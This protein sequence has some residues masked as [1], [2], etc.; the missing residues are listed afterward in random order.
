MN[1][2]VRVPGLPASSLLLAGLLALCGVPGA[3]TIQ[4]DI[5][6]LQYKETSTL[7]NMLSLVEQVSEDVTLDASATFSAERSKDLDRFTD[8]RSGSAS[9][10]YKP[11]DSVELSANLSRLLDMKE[12]YGGLISDQLQNTAT[13][14]V[15]CNPGDWLSMTVGMG[16]HFEEYRTVSGDSL[17][18]GDDRGGVTNISVSANYGLAE[19]LSASLTF[20]EDRTLGRQTDR[21]QDD[22]SGRVSYE[23]PGMFDGGSL[24]AQIGASRQQVVYHD[25]SYSNNLHSYCSSFTVTCPTMLQSLSLELTANWSWEDK[26]WESDEDSTWS[27]ED[28]RD[29]L[30]QQ[31]GLTGRV[32]WNLMDDLSLEF[33][34]GRAFTREDRKQIA[35][36]VSDLFDVWEEGDDRSLVAK[37]TYDIGEARITFDR[38]I[39]LY[40]FDTYGVWEDVFGNPQEDNYDRDELR[41]SMTLAADIPVDGR[42]TLGALLQAQRQET[43]YIFAEQSGNNKVSSTYSFSP[44]ATYQ[45]GGGWKLDETLDFS[46][47]YT[48]FTYPEYSSTGNNLL[49]RRVESVLSFRRI[50]SDSTQLGFTNRFRFQDNGAYESSVYSRSEERISNKVTLYGGFHI[51]SGLGVTPTYSY[52]YSRRVLLGSSVPPSV[53]NLHHVGIDCRMDLG[54]GRLTLNATR[55]FYSDDRPSYWT[56][57]AGFGY[58]F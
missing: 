25:S 3:Y 26:Y 50:S 43:I 7:T 18:S 49:F 10:T 28:S 38:V 8:T 46:A 4:Y 20:G 23:F 40:R 27:G 51:R 6:L 35:V 2:R 55:T 11:V 47:D 19:R 30:D 1:P 33:S 37:V 42:L 36:G 13:G 9:L 48:T 58:L 29:R 22:I 45:L 44:T 41:E 5:S 57:S 21:N 52:E 14:Q 12:R 15:R 17:I 34:L 31:R 56:A 24:L 32:L 39:E 53:D 16:T 54:G